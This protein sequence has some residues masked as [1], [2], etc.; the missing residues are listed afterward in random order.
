MMMVARACHSSEA[1]CDEQPPDVMLLQTGL[2]SGTT[3]NYRLGSPKTSSIKSTIAFDSNGGIVGTN[4]GTT[5]FG[6]K[7]GI[8]ELGA[9]GELATHDK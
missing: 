8:V 9:D 7:N 6:M 1:E 4:D 2:E 3:V 5:A